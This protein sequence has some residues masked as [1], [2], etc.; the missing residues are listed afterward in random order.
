MTHIMRKGCGG[1]SRHTGMGMAVVQMSL[2]MCC[3]TRAFDV[4]GIIF[5][6]H[7]WRILHEWSFHMKFMEKISLLQVL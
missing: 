7:I 2:H 6:Y 3:L 1:S 4:Y 5:Q